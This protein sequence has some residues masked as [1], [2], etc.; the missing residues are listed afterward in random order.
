M[1]ALS[2]SVP[3]PI[4]N[5]RDGQ[6][7][8]NG[9]VYIGTPYLD[10]QINPVQVYFDEALTIPAYQPLRTINGYV[11]NAGTPAQ[12]YVNGVNFS[13][14]VLDKDANLVYTFANGTGI[15]PNA[16]GVQYDPAGVGAVSTTVQAKLRQTVSVKDFGAVGD[17]VTNDT[18]AFNNAKNYVQS[19]KGVLRIPSGTYRLQ[20]AM[21][22]TANDTDWYFDAGS[23]LKLVD[24]Q[25]TTSFITFTSPTNQ[26]IFGMR[27]NGNRP[28][29]NATLFGEDNCAVLVVNATNCL[30]SCIEI[31]NSPA[32]GFALVSTPAGYNRDVSIVNFTGANCVEQVLIV[33]GNNITGFFER[34]V[35]DNVKIG[36]TSGFGLCL[37][38][39]AGQI[40]VSN[41]IAEINNTIADAIYIRDSFDIQLSN[42]RGSSA[43]NGIGIER[44]NG[45]TGR[46]EMSNVC[47]EFNEQNGIIFI[48][49]ENITAT[50]IAG[51]NNKDAGINITQTGGSYRSKK[52]NISNCSAYDNRGGSAQQDYGVLASAV[53]DCIIGDLI[54]YGNTVRNLSILRATTSNVL[55]NTLQSVSVTTGAIASG[56]DATITV[57]WPLA[58]EDDQIIIESLYVL[59]GTSSLSLQILHVIAITQAAIQ[60]KVRNVG[61]STFTGT[62][63]ASAYRKS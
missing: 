20:S 48:G 13:I 33:D 35:I 57:T 42:I 11:S 58:F 41:V 53:D 14:K 56:A 61:A 29:Q 62:L 21:D 36:A 52:I 19:V 7:L 24:T 16:S 30:F 50:S 22:F 27:V 12:L 39:G 47:G 43:R 25:A 63:T 55:A 4:F 17:G 49:A 59:V 5:D 44:L 9:Y 37:N 45:F 32:K 23:I 10:P 18:T 38:D 26:R 2:I 3:F 31:I 34:I 40:S 8:D 54:A 1:P 15:N 51:L 6:P 60:V 28:I 46:I